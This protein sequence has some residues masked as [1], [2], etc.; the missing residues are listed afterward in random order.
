MN[1]IR[2]TREQVDR[3]A[4]WSKDRNPLHT[5]ADYARGTHFG[6]PLVHGMLG[7]ISAL[8][9]SGG[10][11]EAAGRVEIEFRG[12]MVE[13]VDYAVESHTDEERRTLVMRSAD[14]KQLIVQV[15]PSPQDLAMDLWWVAI[16]PS[17]LRSEAAPLEFDDLQSGREAIGIYDGFGEATEEGTSLRDRVLALCSYVI[18]MELPGLR[19]L[20]TRA[21]VTFAPDAVAGAE[22]LFHARVTRVDRQFR[23]ADVRVDVASADG[24]PVAT[25]DLRAYVRFTP[26]AALPTPQEVAPDVSGK[27]RG[28]VALVC[29]GTR[30][31]GAEITAELAMA[32]CRVYA[33]YARD[34]VAGQTLAAALQAAGAEV[35]LLQ[36]DAAD[37]AWNERVRDTIEADH[38]RLDMLVLSA[39]APPAAMPLD[40][41]HR[42]AFA[43]YVAG[44]LALAQVPTTAFLPLL[45]QAGGTI[46]ALSSSFVTERPQG[47]AHYVALKQAVEGTVM[48]AAGEAPG[49]RTLIARPPRLLTTWN[50]T[51]AGVLGAIPPGTAASHIV[52]RLADDNADVS[53]LL[54]EFP[55][56]TADRERPR[57]DPE[58]SIGLT[59]T[60]TAEPILPGLN[61]WFDELGI[62]GDVD[63]APYGQVLQTLLSP[64]GGLTRPPGMH[65]ILLRLQD[66]LRELS[67]DQSGSAEFVRNFLPSIC[68]D[69][70]R[71]IRTHRAHASAGTMLVLCPSTLDPASPVVL[72]V[73]EAETE[74]R[75]RLDGIPGL[76]IVDASAWHAV[77]GVD[78]AHIADPVR[79]RIGHIPYQPAY[80]HTL[81]AIVMRHVH[82][83]LAPPRKVVVVDCDNTLWRGI[84]G[85]AG[86]QGLEFADEHRHLHDVLGRLSA[87]GVLI[88]L[89]SKN[90]EADV[91]R[92]FDERPELG[93]R[94]DQVV[95]AM[96]NWLPK[97]QNLSTIAARLNLG[98]DSFVFI[99]DNPVE[100]A[101]V[102]AACPEVLTLE[103]PQDAE[104]ARALLQHCWELDP[105]T[106]TAEDQR[107]TALYQ[108][109]FRR[110]ELQAQTLTFRDFIAS[111]ELAVDISPLTA[112]DLK[113]ASQ[114]TLR[115]NQFNFTTQ[116]RDETELQ[117]LSANGAYEI[118]T[119]RV[120]DRF[121]DY[122]LVGLLIAQILEHEV[123]ADTFLLSCRVLGRGVEHQMINE[124]GRIAAAHG[125][126]TVRLRVEPTKRNTPARSF[127]RSLVPDAT[128]DAAGIV[129]TAVDATWAAQVSFEPPEQAGGAVVEEAPGRATEVD[130]TRLRSR[131]QQIARAA[132]ALSTASRLRAAIERVPAEAAAPQ[133]PSADAAAAVETAFAAALGIDAAR[134]REIDSLEA[135]GC[136]SFRIVEITVGLI[137]KF[138]WLPA[139]LLFE[140]KSVSAIIAKISALSNGERDAPAAIAPATSVVIRSV[141]GESDIAVVGMHLRCAGA[142][143]PEALWDLLSGKGVAVKPVPVD[144][145]AFF[146]RLD[147]D[148]T[149]FAGFLEEVDGFE[150]EAFGIT[151]REAE[152]MDPQLRLFLEVAWAALEDAGALSDGFEPDTGVFAGVMYS[153]YAH[154]ANV[155]ARRGDTPFKSW[156]AFSLANRLSQ[157][158]G[159]SGPSLAIDTACSSSG[160]ALHFACRAIKAGDCR[161]AVVGG[162]NLILDPDRFVQLGRLGILSPSG[163]CL[164]FGAEADGTVLG[165]GAGV[166]VLRPLAEA[167]RRGDRIYGV[168]KAT[169]V[170]TGSG[171]VGFTAPNPQAQAE[172]VRRAVHSA[173]ID[174]RTISYVETHGTATALG[175]PIEVRGLSLA[176]G[177]PRLWDQTLTLEQRC[178][179]GSIKPNIGHLEAGAGVLGLIKVLL[180]LQRRMLLPSVTSAQANP[181]IPFDQTPFSIQRELAPWPQPEVSI[182]GSRTLVPRRAALNSFGVGGA[183]VHMIL[184]EGPVPREEDP[185]DERTDHL[186]VLSARTSESLDRRLAATAGALAGSTEALGNLCF[187]A[188][189]GRRHLEYRAAVT[190]RSKEVMVEALH[191]LSSGDD[192][193]GCSRGR[194][195]RSAAAPKVAFLFTGQG[196]QYA[197]MGRDLYDAHPAFRAAVDRCFE[198]F[199]PLL[200]RSLR[201][202]MFAEAGTPEGERLNQTG[203]TQPALFTLGYAL[204]ELW[205]SWGVKPDVML[206]HSVGEI[207]AMCAAGGL[208]LEDAVTLIAA[209]GRLMQAL[210]HGGAMTSVMTA[211]KRVLEAIAGY[212]DRVAVAAI[213]GPSQVVISGEGPVV[214]SIAAQLS[215]AGVRTRD[216]VVSHAFH[217]P[218]MRPMLAEY[219]AVARTLRFS[220]PNVGIVSCVLGRTAGPELTDPG[221]WVRNVIDP[222]RFTDGIHAIDAMGVKA[223]VELGPQ[224]ILIGMGRQTLGEADQQTWVPSLR[225][226]APA[227]PTMLAGLGRLYVEGV[228]VDWQGFDSRWRRRRVAL[229]SYPFSRRRFWIDAA[230]PSPAAV[231]AA[232]RAA[233]GVAPAAK[234]Y[235]VAWREK[236]QGAAEKVSQKLQGTRWAVIGHAG[237]PQIEALQRTLSGAG[238][239]VVSLPDTAVQDILEPGLTGIIQL[240]SPTSVGTDPIRASTEL[241]ET[242]G[243]LMRSLA[244]SAGTAPRLFI[245]TRRGVATSTAS[246][247]TV[248][249][250][251][252]A[253]WGAARTFALEH[254]D[255]WGGLIDVVGDAAA[256][257]TAIAG[258]LAASGT[259]EQVAH[260][261]HGRFVP[262]LV[263]RPFSG[264]PELPVKPTGTYL[265]TGGL[266]ALG[267]QVAGWLVSRGA[268]HLVLTGRRGLETPGAEAGVKALEAAGASVTVVKGDTA[269]ASE[270]D[271]AFA[272]V[273]QAAPL[274]GVFHAAGVDELKAIEALEP[275]D[276][277]RVMSG[278]A[279]GA[280][281]LHE[282][283]RDL[284]L[285]CFVL[286]SSIASVLGSA[287]RMAYASANAFLDA[288]ACTR[289]AE[290]LPGVSINWGPWAG[291]G[292]ATAATLE[293]YA[294][295]GNRGIQPAEGLRLLEAALAGSLPQVAIADIDWRTFRGAY[296]ARRPKPLIAELLPSD[297]GKPA[298]ARR[299]PWIEKLS[300]L[301]EHRRLEELTGLLRAEIAQT[302]GFSAAT[303]VA[304]DQ[305]FRDMGM[306]S[307]MSADFAQRL[308]KKVGIRGTTVV[309]EHPQVDL[310]AAHLAETLTS[311]L[312]P[313]AP[314]GE[315]ARL[316]EAG[317]SAGSGIG[318]ADLERDALAFQHEAY[319]LRTTELIGPRWRWMFVDSARRLGFEPRVWL[320]RHEGQVVGH[321]GAI[322]VILKVGSGERPTGW[323]VETMVLEA[324]RAD[325]V[326]TRLMLEAQD[327]LPFALSL[328]QTASMRE[329]QVRLGWEQVAPLETAQL[330]VNPERVLR[331][332]LPAPV[333]FA[334]G[335]GFRAS[336]AGRGARR[337]LDGEAAREIA[338]FGQ[339]HDALWNRMAEDVTCAVRRDA[340]YLNWKY[341]DQPGQQFLRL[342]LSSGDDVR[343]VVVCAFRE[344]DNIYRY[345]R[346][347]IVDLV[348]PLRDERLLQRLIAVA[349][350]ACTERGADAV[351]CLHINHALTRALRSSGFR[352]RQPERHL[353]VLP[354]GLNT[355]ARRA[356]LSRDAWF[357]TQGDS[358]IDRPW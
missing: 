56:R 353:L 90:E 168:I 186:L 162:V 246:D 146:G 312:S 187:S 326:G 284:P 249:L 221:Y 83:T 71:A 243:S 207:T 115:T 32:G 68:Q 282:R 112:A 65:V 91:W 61:F 104:R 128:V 191:A 210:P 286:F 42:E 307:L 344:P 250:A 329:I 73:T 274:A 239:T 275:G 50:D 227:L 247:T 330:L 154:R 14:A 12:A 82:R 157:I 100:C 299:A 17:S 357:V 133:V 98:L 3:F 26:S 336:Q 175:D 190:A 45:R 354:G 107:R 114:L 126:A 108:E 36:G 351:L 197:G 164:A 358:D 57:T 295:I 270:V 283:T 265:I 219:E 79:E 315:S 218:L 350:A 347:L 346:A 123:L 46:V 325:G 271:L 184:E 148:R 198:L 226:D 87:G 43:D 335:M 280:W 15:G 149:H 181:H 281:Y 196:S 59:A 172:A 273:S 35:H 151:P 287:Q 300:T 66:W 169:G 189:T 39:C 222:V 215:A 103:W 102:R 165:E 44:N 231:P 199:E 203:C 101:E 352:L 309:F 245:V 78:E 99:D 159:F 266:G 323:L 53:V 256:M 52:T 220:Q 29:G 232:N 51:P 143:S 293:Q 93:L 69:L 349:V 213:N 124:L 205:R 7:V 153:D 258:E 225:K 288:L 180:Q 322:P 81:A 285:N 95:C 254:P 230:D 72:A 276:V 255:V 24:R 80:F 111:L 238:A 139:T 155:V 200:E 10:A 355:E 130:A 60:F 332:K 1:T 269:V 308:K 216:L 48:S 74:L 204:S 261:P 305:P 127:V 136:D 342:E 340:S 135:L 120:R 262:R 16:P 145:P 324:H 321:N 58:L 310:L 320:H 252:A 248:D 208:S 291:G 125:R 138:P 147:D 277:T 96:V 6:R 217:S 259:E 341:V 121:G 192:P 319:P 338:S 289:R 212:E 63:V 118:R 296:E 202:T 267:L 253:L 49:V 224:P 38:G 229:P 334:A 179:I 33:S 85:E 241:C 19:A 113:R 161:V 228:E 167:L 201:A 272:A 234:M 185:E 170:S 214:A 260:R 333:A 251:H 8:E 30:G 290:G 117:A 5:D 137:E 140:H 188:N 129:E 356:V 177:D 152:L 297:G 178:A 76:T 279:G 176:Y 40:A 4:A 206:G 331:G 328:G 233:S 348:A 20:F 345:R 88:A 317:L 131:E 314:D 264:V 70:E 327:A 55:A 54:T 244:A 64:G 263:L 89:C 27:L 67:Q 92:V 306:D 173:L 41:A 142:D 144:R 22:L 182:D 292:M 339:P 171:T 193:V 156:E 298:D 18:G 132:Y 34:A 240:P 313:A 242:A 236:T 75:A 278:K 294:R 97:S 134:V 11:R 160:T 37:P 235:E 62:R 94:R 337:P 194:I 141:H 9:S 77:Y 166:V 302:L 304:I 195:G 109:E 106:S 268:R 303:D 174:P 209:R 105:R 86:V 301:P 257:A 158:F 84:V 28:K 13:D 31:L 47:F 163:R 318:T 110:Q 122:G 211:E 21:S 311:Q 183:N 343:G 119:V 25:A 150:P 2:F 116:R 23:L 237:D 316:P 223:F